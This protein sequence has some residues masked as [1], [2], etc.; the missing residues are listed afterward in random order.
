MNELISDLGILYMC[1]TKRL[2]EE[3][4]IYLGILLLILDV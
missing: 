1:D 3:F 4:F 2:Q